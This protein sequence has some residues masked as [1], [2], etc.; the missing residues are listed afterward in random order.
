MKK[1]IF[2]GIV[3]LLSTAIW[4]QINLPRPDLNPFRVPQNTLF[5]PNQLTINHSV[6]FEAGG[7]SAGDGFYLSRYTNHIHYKFNPKLEMN[8]DLS[9]VNYGTAT[10]SGKVDFNDDNRNKV[11]PEFSLSYRPSDNVRFDIRFEQGLSNPY[12]TSR[13]NRW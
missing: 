11:I 1:L 13:Y 12:Y 4:G 9:F 2:I 10:T 8:I 6:G 3:V 7:S 5:N